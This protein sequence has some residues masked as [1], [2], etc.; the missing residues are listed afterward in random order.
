MIQHPHTPASLRRTSRW[1]GVLFLLP[2]LAYGAGNAWM[3][4][5]RATPQAL[6]ELPAQRLPLLLAGL[7]LL[8]NS[9]VVVL[10][11]VQVYPLIERLRPRVALAYLCVRMTEALLLAGGLL[12]LLLLPELVAAE[13]AGAGISLV[14]LAVRTNFLAFQLAMLVLGVGSV[15]FCWM[16][17]RAGLVPLALA[18]WGLLGYALLAVGAVLEL[19]G[20][21]YGVLLSL[22]GGLFEVALGVWLLA[23]GFNPAALPAITPA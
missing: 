6:A 1:T 19:L 8:L 18:W 12:A 11:A 13:Q 23:K 7:L 20:L 21:P 3:E 16:L 17:G 9:V 22:P 10:I 5:L 15:A 4:A 2:L 14:G